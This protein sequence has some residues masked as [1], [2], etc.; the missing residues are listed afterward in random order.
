MRTITVE[1]DNRV[2]KKH[3]KNILFKSSARSIVQLEALNGGLTPAEIWIEVNNLLDELRS[4]DKNDREVMICQF[5]I[6]YYRK[7]SELERNGKIISRNSDDVNRTLTCVFYCLKLSLKANYPDLS[8]NP[9][10]DIIEALDMMLNSINHPILDELKRGI[11]DDVLY[12]QQKDGKTQLPSD[13]LIEPDNDW[14]TQLYKILGN[15]SQRT[16]RLIEQTYIDS[17]CLLW[18]NLGKD[19]RVSQ[20]LKIPTVIKG[21][22]HTELGVCYNAKLLFNI[23]GMLYSRGFFKPSVKGE[24]PLS[25]L[26]S[27]HYDIR[28]GMKVRARY[29]YFKPESVNVK[30]QFLGADPDLYCHID[31]LIRE[32]LSPVPIIK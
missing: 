9:N 27:E 32:T 21:D 14:N 12:Y 20:Q 16:E 4:V 24:T 31:K 11:K 30:P 2:F 26:V 28:T 7:F 17:F 29:E 6:I 3:L 18:Q 19:T 10:K 5:R 8:S 25:A 23:Y 22:E 1:E 13:P 15:Y